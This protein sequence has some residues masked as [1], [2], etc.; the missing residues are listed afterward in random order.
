M[1]KAS[2]KAPE[3]ASAEA[4]EIPSVDSLATLPE[5]VK[6]G[7]S[8]S[9]KYLV[10]NLLKDEHY[11]KISQSLAS[12]WDKCQSM[13]A[14]MKLMEQSGVHITPEEE[15]RLSGLTEAQMIESLVSKMPQ[16]S[17]E[18]FQHFFLQLQLIVST[19]TRV[20]QALEAGRSDLVEQAMDDAEST[21]IVQYILKLTIVQAGS[22]VTNLKKTHAAFVKDAEGKLSR[23]VKASEDAQTAKERLQKAMAELAV[24]SATANENI[25][26]V[27]MAFAGGSRTALLHGVVSTWHNYCK[28]MKVENEIYEE[29]REELEYAEKRLIEAKSDQLKSITGMV[30]RRHGGK[31]VSLTQEVFDLWKND[32]AEAKDLI[33]SKGA[34]DALEA[35]FAGM[36][37]Q[38]SANAKRVL[39]R[40][41]SASQE[42]MR[43][44]CFVEWRSY[45]AWYQKHLL[46]EEAVKAEEQRIQDFLK[47]HSEKGKALLGSISAATDSGLMHEVLMA[48]NEQYKEEK[49]VNEY[50]KVMQEKNQK[51]AAFGARNKKGAASV[52]G[53]A[54]EHANCMLYLKVFGSWRLD[55]RME[56]L[57]KVHQG[58]I[59]GKRSQLAGVQKKFRE[60]ALQL[61]NNINSGADSDRALGGAEY[62]A[63]QPD[64]CKGRKLRT[65]VV[66]TTP[67]K[68]GQISLPAIDQKARPGSSEK[69]SD[70]A[71]KQA[72]S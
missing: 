24:F 15:Q 18:Q 53:K 57:L 28:K 13:N 29:Y 71:P 32:T 22:E 52:M 68:E 9:V 63:K 3:P 10:G 23:M 36:N 12:R 27:L 4:P 42:Q 16:Q 51:G 8:A 72:W 38:A 64:A 70:R 54:E 1:S 67:L 44:M 14:A 47:G 59:E 40:C 30:N 55:T 43:D 7:L 60:F 50:A 2:V 39:A 37:A 21:G 66:T 17:K 62:L 41:G 56:Q 20:R 25:K 65:S 58:R 61:E 34:I 35:K 48:W 6:K 31:A 33:A 19:A 26:K 46:E 69:Q 45:H 49:Q 11:S 5:T